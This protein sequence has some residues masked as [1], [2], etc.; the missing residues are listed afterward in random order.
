MKRLMWTYVVMVERTIVEHHHITAASIGDANEKF[1]QKGLD[2]GWGEPAYS[3]ELESEVREE[4]TF[5]L[6]DD[7]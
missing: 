7:E 1:V 4:D 3:E 6:L 5:L 2:E